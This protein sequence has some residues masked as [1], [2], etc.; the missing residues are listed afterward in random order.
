MQLNAQ[1]AKL[2]GAI[3]RLWLLFVVGASLPL[4]QCGGDD[5]GH[6][7]HPVNNAA[8]L[9]NVPSYATV[10]YIRD[11]AL[12]NEQLSSFL[13]SHRLS[14]LV[15]TGSRSVTSA[16]LQGIE[17]SAGLKYLNVSYTNMDDGVSEHLAKLHNLEVFEARGTQVQTLSSVVYESNPKLRYVNLA[18]CPVTREMLE[19]CITYGRLQELKLARCTELEPEDISF[20]ARSKTLRIIDLSYC[21]LSPTVLAQL[22][23]IATLES[24]DVQG[25]IGLSVEDVEKVRLVHTKIHIVF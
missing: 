10:I 23:S 6:G 3:R 21:S 12:T 16:G 25:A 20:L 19:M 18:E 8:E 4:L 15:A 5:S 7:I 14:D 13:R 9:P 11:P 17:A 2:I 22:C 1:Y 24:L